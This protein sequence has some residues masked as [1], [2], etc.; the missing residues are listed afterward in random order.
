MTSNNPPST[1][2]T[3]P[4]SA[5]VN[6]LFTPDNR[7]PVP[8]VLLPPAS[9]QMSLENG[10]AWAQMKAKE[11]LQKKQQA[12][13]KVAIPLKGPV[14][15]KP[16]PKPA[17]DYRKFS[18]LNY[19]QELALPM[20]KPPPRG[21]SDKVPPATPEPKPTAHKLHKRGSPG[22]T[23]D[24]RD[25][26]DKERDKDKEKEK[27]KSRVAALKSKFS[28]KDIGKDLRKDGP[29]TSLPAI[30][31]SGSEGGSDDEQTPKTVVS[32]THDIQKTRLYVPKLEDTGVHPMSAPAKLTSNC[33]PRPLLSP[34][35]T[36]PLRSA[37]VQIP[38]YVSAKGTDSSLF[39]ESPAANRAAKLNK[40]APDSFDTPKAP[41]STPE[42]VAQLPAVCY[43]PSLYEDDRIARPHSPGEDTEA[44]PPKPGQVGTA[45]QKDIDAP[46]SATNAN[47]DQADQDDT[48][49]RK[50]IDTPAPSTEPKA[51][52]TKAGPDATATQKKVAE[53]LAALATI[54]KTDYTY[55]F[56]VS[57]DPRPPQTN[58]PTTASHYENTPFTATPAENAPIPMAF[59][60]QA[61]MSTAAVY[62][63][64]QTWWH[65]HALSAHEQYAPY[66]YTSYGGYAPPPPVPGYQNTMSLEQQLTD[67]VNSLHHHITGAITKINK[68][69]D[70][71]HS[72]TLDQIMPQ[73]ESI[74]DAIRGWNSEAARIRE[75]N[76]AMGQFRYQVAVM[77]DQMFHVNQSLSLLVSGVDTLQRDASRRENGGEGKPRGRNQQARKGPTPAGRRTTNRRDN[78]S[79]T[80]ASSAERETSDIGDNVPTPVAAFRTPIP[81]FIQDSNAQIE[82][83][84][85]KDANEENNKRKDGTKDKYY[86]RTRPNYPKRSDK[87]SCNEART[88]SGA[89][90]AA[91]TTKDTTP[92][93]AAAA[94]TITTQ[95]DT[96]TKETSPLSPMSIASEHRLNEHNANH[97]PIPIP[98]AA[99]AT[100]QRRNLRGSVSLQ[101]FNVGN[102]YAP[103][104]AT[105]QPYRVPG[106]GPQYP[107][108]SGGGGGGGGN[109]GRGGAGMQC[110]R[111][112]SGP[113]P[114]VPNTPHMQYAGGWNGY[115][116]GNGHGMSW[117]YGQ[118]QGL[119]YGAW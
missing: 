33:E 105:Y 8:R 99:S 107:S 96:E 93:N 64:N 89:T 86:L 74:T 67:N 35:E 119:A 100:P 51:N 60:H 92:N 56:I 42:S 55:P 53:T 7:I 111:P 14:M 18:G 20:P 73:L 48:T 80:V 112:G 19:D 118:E 4:T 94:G 12:L 104:Q 106:S 81:S 24:E 66:A 83:N 61:S 43:S 16:P 62:D 31:H 115:S 58:V 26:K 2:P 46:A 79:S 116:Y 22:N 91:D 108:V 102:P 37:G 114:T 3:T 54:P 41:P 71:T 10:N 117:Y 98:A 47:A 59:D 15:P 29:L 30:P 32:V 13:E 78:R 57:S 21:Q 65:Q 11:K 63:P 70:S 27:K 95:S 44:E 25:D 72:R 1:T 17:G 75:L 113:G 103:A 97:A 84:N 36:T 69:F 40:N 23:M 52:T 90:K 9:I 49:E 85:T 101:N 76:H 34:D 110:G 45:E 77:Q 6:N 87:G 82:P 28:L 68:T 50:A 5:L 39:E 38:E 88:D 109:H